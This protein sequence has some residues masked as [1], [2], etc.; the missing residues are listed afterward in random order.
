MQKNVLQVAGLYEPDVPII[1]L[2]EQVDVRIVDL[3]TGRY[4]DKSVDHDEYDPEIA[5]KRPEY[6][7]AISRDNDL[8]GLKRREKMSAVYLVHSPPGKLQQLIIPVRG[9]GLW[10]TLYGFLAVDID[11]TTVRG[12]TFY[13]HKET[14]GLGGEIDNPRWKSLWNG[15]KIFDDEW[16]MK[17][18]VVKGAASSDPAPLQPQMRSASSSPVLRKPCQWPRGVNTTSPFLAGSSPSSVKMMPLPDITTRNSSQ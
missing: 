11:A 12:I 9:K 18:E 16:E 17:L 6:S 2:F 4:V 3:K 1:E 15:K 5:P 7:V 14:P 8:A 10:S 13:E